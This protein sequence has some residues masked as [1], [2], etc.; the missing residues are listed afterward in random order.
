M[1]R[2]T[3]SDLRFTQCLVVDAAFDDDVVQGCV[4]RLLSMRTCCGARS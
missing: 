1:A 4:V 3:Q 2:L